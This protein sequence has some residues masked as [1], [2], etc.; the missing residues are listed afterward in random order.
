MDLIS[1]VSLGVEFAEEFGELEIVGE[2]GLLV[3]GELVEEGEEVFGVEGG[4][5]SGWECGVGLAVGREEE[6]CAVGYEIEQGL[7]LLV[8]A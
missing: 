5:G 8:R 2:R 6:L 3:C 1:A 7:H 4:G